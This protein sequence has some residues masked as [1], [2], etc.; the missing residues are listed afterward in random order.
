MDFDE[1][2]DVSSTIDGGLT[3]SRRKG[4]IYVAWPSTSV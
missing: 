2:D 3:A 1:V 4:S